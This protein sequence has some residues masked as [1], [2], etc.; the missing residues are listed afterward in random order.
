MCFGNRGRLYFPCQGARHSQYTTREKRE[1]L[2]CIFI[3]W[4]LVII[5]FSKM[6]QMGQFIKLKR[7]HILSK[8]GLQYLVIR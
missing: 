1:E 5:R 7:R 6:C 8:R 4:W 3:D 2:D